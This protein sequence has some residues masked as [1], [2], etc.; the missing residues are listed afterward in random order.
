MKE[1]RYVLISDY[2]QVEAFVMNQIITVEQSSTKALRKWIYSVRK[3]KSQSEKYETTD[4]RCY[5]EE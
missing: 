3:I 2:I 4:I 1:H 5:F